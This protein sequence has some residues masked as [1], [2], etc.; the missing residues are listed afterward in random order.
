[1]LFTAKLDDRDGVG[2]ICSRIGIDHGALV[3][4]SEDDLLDLV[5][6]KETRDPLI[7]F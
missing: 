6:A 2:K 5:T 3:F 4:D 1:M 7:A